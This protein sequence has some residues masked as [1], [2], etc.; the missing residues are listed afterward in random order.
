MT[1]HCQY[2]GLV[3]E[4]QGQDVISACKAG[5]HAVFNSK[6]LHVVWEARLPHRAPVHVLLWSCSAHQFD[7]VLPPLPLAHEAQH[8]S[9]PGGAIGVSPPAPAHRTIQ[10]KQAKR[11]QVPEAAGGKTAAS[12]EAGDFAEA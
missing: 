1:G 6:T 3:R 8:E 9:H 10:R 11:V 7:S 5:D 2:Q 12:G 4:T